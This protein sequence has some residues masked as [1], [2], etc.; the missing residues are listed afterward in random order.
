MS[1]SESQRETASRDQALM[2]LAQARDLI[3][4]STS[5][6][7]SEISI[8]LSRT[9]ETADQDPQPPEPPRL[10]SRRGGMFG[11]GLIGLMAALCLGSAAFVWLTFHNHEE[12]PAKTD[13]S[14]QQAVSQALTAGQRATA[15]VPGT[16]S[17]DPNSAQSIEAIVRELAVLERGIDQLTSGQTQLVQDKAALAEGL[18]STQDATRR[19]LEMVEALRATQAQLSRDNASLVELLKAGQEQ[20]NGV[21]AQLKSSQELTTSVAAQLKAIQ[22]QIA[23]LSEQRPPRSKPVTTAA[24]P[25]TAIAA[26][27]PASSPASQ[28]ARLQT[29]APR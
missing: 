26:R 18:K 15:T 17:T 21:T 5:P 2:A 14:H 23:R 27:K 3:G 7:T 8:D 12:G 24:G 19:I 16:T 13:A 25:A 9:P 1:N 11:R 4:P 6:L 28:P 22:E 10:G 29:S 20:T